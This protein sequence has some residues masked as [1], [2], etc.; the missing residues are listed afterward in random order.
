MRL[1]DVLERFKLTEEDLLFLE[2]CDDEIKVKGNEVKTNSFILEHLS[3]K[4]LG[5]EIYT[6]CGLEITVSIEST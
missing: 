1:S 6:G 4:V 2:T 3:S 5:I